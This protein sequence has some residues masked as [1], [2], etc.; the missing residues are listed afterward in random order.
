[1]ESSARQVRSRVAIGRS[2]GNLQIR[3]NTPF[4]RYSIKDAVSISTA[5][6]F[7][8]VLGLAKAVSFKLPSRHPGLRTIRFRG[9]TPSRSQQRGRTRMAR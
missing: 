1:M 4:V 6:I 3:K 5:A 7:G 2:P 9:F 8:I